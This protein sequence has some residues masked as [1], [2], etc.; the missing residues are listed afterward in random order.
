MPSTRPFKIRPRESEIRELDYDS[1]RLVLQIVLFVWNFFNDYEGTQFTERPST[2]PKSTS[3]LASSVLTHVY[4][5]LYITLLFTDG[6]IRSGRRTRRMSASISACVVVA[7]AVIYAQEHRRWVDDDPG[8][9]VLAMDD[10]PWYFPRNLS[11]DITQTDAF[12]A[13]TLTKIIYF[14]MIGR[15]PF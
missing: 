1:K 13:H 4:R 15:P 10:M 7:L 5:F 11:Q 2:T 14:Y 8:S 3:W 6:R 12:M 9:Y